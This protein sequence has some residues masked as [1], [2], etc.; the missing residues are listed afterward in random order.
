MNL[1][2]DRKREL[3]EAYKLSKSDMGCFLFTCNETNNN[4][5]GITQDLKGSLNGLKFQLG[6]QLCTNKELQN[7]W[8]KYGETGFEITVL[9][10][11][12]YDKDESKKDYSEELE[13][14]K[15]LWKEKILGAKD[16]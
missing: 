1:D 10:Q 9:E 8:T 5:I 16:I 11:L 3:K 13:I 14:L 15:E 2:K 12:N 6:A 4:Y 7:N